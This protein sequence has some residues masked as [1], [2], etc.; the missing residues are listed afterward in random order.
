MNTRNT[1]IALTIVAG[2]LLAACVPV[3]SAAPRTLAGTDWVLATL[4]G[5]AA[6]PDTQVTIRFEDGQLGGTDGCN[7][8]ST[9]YTVN[10]AQLKLDKNVI[11][12]MMACAE[13]IMGQAAAYIAALIQAATYTIEGGQLTLLDAGGKALATFTRQSTGLAGTAWVVTG[14]NNGQQAVVSVI[15]GSQLTADFGVDG[16]LSGSGGCNTFTATYEVSGTTIKIGPIGSTRMACADPAGV[17]A[18]ETQYLLALATA[19]TYAR[20]G[21]RLELR[22]AD[23]AL[24]VIFEVAPAAAN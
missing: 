13:P 5:Q 22:T 11:S 20:E 18:Q 9:S 15:A 16:T 19:A 21:N 17:M 6:L 2:L 24:A 4:N 3:P 23:G 12:T 1:L 10:G 7:R 8:Y 14:Y